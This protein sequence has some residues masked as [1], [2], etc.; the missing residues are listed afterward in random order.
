MPI[1][2]TDSIGE[3]LRVNFYRDISDGTKFEIKFEPQFIGT[4]FP[5]DTPRKVVATLGTVEVV[6]DDMKFL[7]NQYVEY[8]IK[9]DDFKDTG[10][11][12][13]KGIATL[14]SETVATSNQFF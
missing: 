4:R 13:A 9:E 3:I 5:D 10:R 8:T 6:V 7:A 14:P 2:N 11:W 12:Q 1:F